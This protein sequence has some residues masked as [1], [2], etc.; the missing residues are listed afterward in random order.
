MRSHISAPDKPPT[1]TQFK[2]LAINK[3]AMAAPALPAPKADPARV[4][5]IVGSIK[6]PA[7]T[8]MRAWAH[9]LKARADA[10]ERLT[11]T[12]REMMRTGLELEVIE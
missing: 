1:V 5:A 9:R 6:R 2:A 8:A 12:Q 4:A 11:I 10:G 3:P 7:N